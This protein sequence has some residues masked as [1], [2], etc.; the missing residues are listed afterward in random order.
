MTKTK[1]TNHGPK[2]PRLKPA[3]LAGFEE[4]CRQEK[5]RIARRVQELA[6]HLVDYFFLPGKFV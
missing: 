4:K 6:D 1:L 2:L 5:D 3:D